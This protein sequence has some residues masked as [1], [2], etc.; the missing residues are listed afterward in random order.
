MADVGDFDMSDSRLDVVQLEGLVILKIIKHCKEHVP[1]SVTGQL[2]GMDVGATLEVTNSFP[3]PTR[4][5]SDASASDS[6]GD[7]GAGAAEDNAESGA[8]YQLEMMRCLRE[9][10]VDSNTVGWYQSTYLGSFVN[11]SMIETQYNY[12][13]TIPKAVLVVYDSLRTKQGALSLKAYRLTAAFMALY[14]SATFTQESLRDAGLSFADVM[15]EVPTVIHNSHLINAFL[16]ESEADP[17]IPLDFERLDLSTNPFLEKTFELMSEYLDDLSQ[18]Q[19]KYAYYQRTLARQQAQ[20]QAYF[21]RRKQQGLDDDDDTTANPLFKP[22]PSPSRLDALL[23]TNQINNYCHQVN[24]F[25]GNSFS[26]LFLLNSV[27]GAAAGAA[28][29]SGANA[30]DAQK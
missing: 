26:K 11:E 18:E 4:D 25:A 24:Q 27:S 3:F 1:E 7:S 15:E 16:Y 9:V 21:N 29:D 23:I 19:N 17:K 5:T 28:D 30:K 2:L 6:T 8:E 13:V 14:K 10:N 20:Q 22:I 12:Q